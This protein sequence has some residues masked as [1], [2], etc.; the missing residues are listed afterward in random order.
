MAA[1]RTIFE[2]GWGPA[3]VWMGQDEAKTLSKEER[4]TALEEIGGG[5]YQLNVVEAWRARNAQT[6][7]G[8]LG[9]DALAM[10]SQFLS[11][12]MAS[13][14]TVDALEAR[15]AVET[16]ASWVA[17]PSELAALKSWSEHAEALF[18]V[19]KPHM[20]EPPQPPPA[21][22]APE[23]TGPSVKEIVAIGGVVAGVALLVAVVA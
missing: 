4:G 22:A 5:R 23:P 18:N 9:P 12:A 13:T 3:S 17:K 7:R 15:L 1:V 19:V 6:F 8:I 20:T 10:Y 2:L 11:K 16:P 14:R 21:E